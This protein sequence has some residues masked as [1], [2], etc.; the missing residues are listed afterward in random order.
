VGWGGKGSWISRREGF[1]LNPGIWGHIEYFIWRRVG[2]YPRPDAHCM[3]LIYRKVTQ[4]MS[5]PRGQTPGVPALYPLLQAWDE[6]RPCVWKSILPW[7]CHFHLH[8]RS[9]HSAPVLLR[10]CDPRRYF[11]VSLT[12]LRTCRASQGDKG[13]S[14]QFSDSVL[15]AVCR[16]CVPFLGEPGFT[17]TVSC[18]LHKQTKPLTLWSDSPCICTT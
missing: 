2:V 18:S 15:H 6:Y 10:G 5:C 4:T 9:Q 17:C 13:D 3:G 1:S 12:V 16:S 11:R 8:F 7:K 14:P